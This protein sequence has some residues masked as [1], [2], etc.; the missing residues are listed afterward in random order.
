MTDG[1]ALAGGL[2]S[3][4]GGGGAGWYVWWLT[5]QRCHA[6]THTHT[7]TRTHKH[8]YSQCNDL[9]SLTVHGP[10]GRSNLLHAVP[11]TKFVVFFSIISSWWLSARIHAFKHTHTHTHTHTCSFFDVG[12]EAE[13]VL[14]LGAGFMV[15]VS[16]SEHMLSLPW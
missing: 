13:V 4:G 9:D 10:S 16:C 14:V 5:Y 8:E 12:L 11:S 6:H 2:G 1:S 15:A 3:D 7:H